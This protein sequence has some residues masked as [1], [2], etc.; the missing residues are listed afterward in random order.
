MTI[1]LHARQGGQVLKASGPVLSDGPD[2]THF[3]HFCRP[4]LSFRS[5]V[6]SNYSYHGSDPCRSSSTKQYT[7]CRLMCIKKRQVWSIAIFS[8]VHVVIDYQG[9]SGVEGFQDMTLV[10][11]DNTCSEIE[12]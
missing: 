8:L 3:T 9:P 1:L 11:W 6:M 12:A 5:E 4:L 7:E 2:R 10:D